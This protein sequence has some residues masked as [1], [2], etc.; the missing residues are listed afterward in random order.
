MRHE[1]AFLLLSPILIF[2]VCSRYDM[3]TAPLGNSL[4]DV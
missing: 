2:G 3:D 1:A 4:P